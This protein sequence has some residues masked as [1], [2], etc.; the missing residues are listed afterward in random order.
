MARDEDSDSDGGVPRSTSG[1]SWTSVESS[2]GG[3][4]FE[5]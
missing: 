4:R 3:A 5:S 2:G 1:S